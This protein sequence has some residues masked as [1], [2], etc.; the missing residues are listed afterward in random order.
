MFSIL[1]I[2]D[3]KNIRYFLKE[4]LELEHYTVYTAKDGLE[5][6]DIF[7][8]EYIDLVIVDIMMPNMNGY[9]FTKTLRSINERLP[10]LM[11]SAKQLPN[12]RKLGFK[13]GI[14]DFM[15]KPLDNEE[16]ILHV[17]AL[18]KRFKINNDRRI[19]INDVTLNYD[20][21]TI[22]TKNEI[23]ELPQK[24]FLLI[25]KLL[26]YPNKIFTKMELMDEIWG[27]DCDTGWETLTVHVNRLRKKLKDI[28]D[29][30]IVSIRGLGYK[31]VKKNEFK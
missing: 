6:L 1:V 24:E 13:A 4:V 3:D 5:A 23:I 26:S 28:E 30:E 11:I 9:E 7:D 19:I 10:I 27:I 8:K 14:D 31:A 29:F 2:D 16:L 22:T 21:Y 18:L 17:N 12:D 20:S 15:S 25:Y